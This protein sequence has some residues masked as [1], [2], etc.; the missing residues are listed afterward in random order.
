MSTKKGDDFEEHRQIL[1]SRAEDIIQNAPHRRSVSLKRLSANGKQQWI[2]FPCR[3]TCQFFS[4]I[5]NDL[6]DTDATAKEDKQSEF[7]QY[8]NVPVQKEHNGRII[9]DAQ[10]AFRLDSLRAAGMNAMISSPPSKAGVE[11]FRAE[12][13]AFSRHCRETKAVVKPE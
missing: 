9:L 12:R 2:P 3:R 4:V 11:Q 5:I 13:P 7:K 8:V 10:N 6:T 1:Y